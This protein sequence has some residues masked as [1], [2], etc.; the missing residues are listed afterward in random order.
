[1]DKPIDDGSGQWLTED[2]YLTKRGV[3][4][5]GTLVIETIRTPDGGREH[6]WK[7]A[8][9]LCEREID[10]APCPPSTPPTGE[11]RAQESRVFD[12]TASQ[13]EERRR[14]IQRVFGKDVDLAS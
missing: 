5:L 11:H 2:Q 10:D 6:F 4:P 7:I 14:F 9:I 12:L 1:M 8:P 3:R 13:K